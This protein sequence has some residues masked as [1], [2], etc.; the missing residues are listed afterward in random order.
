MGK[1]IINGL[2]VNA[3]AKTT[4]VD[5][6]NVVIIDSADNNKLKSLTWANIKATIKAYTD[7]LYPAIRN[8][9]FQVQLVADDT[10]VASQ[11]AYVRIPSNYNGMTLQRAI[12]DVTTAGT[13]NATTI[14][15][16]NMTKYSSNDALSSAISIAS[17]DTLAT[18]GTVNA[19]YDDVATNDL[20]KIYVTGVSTT[21]PKGLRVV[22]EY[23]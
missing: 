1:T 10:D 11:I 16:R 2:M 21:A 3:T 20:I 23:K 14:Q 19:S 4:P 13:T 18:A 7:T 12:A 9:S 8:E 17:G 5:A 15:V 6:D 22:L